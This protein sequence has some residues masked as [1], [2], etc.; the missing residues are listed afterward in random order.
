MDSFPNLNLNT[1]SFPIAF[2]IV[3]F[4]GA[5]LKYDSYL[6]LSMSK[7]HY[8]SNSEGIMKKIK[9]DYIKLR[10]CEYLDFPDIKKENFDAMGLNLGVCPEN[11]NVNINGYWSTPELT[12]LEVYLNMCN[13]EI[14]LLSTC[15][16]QTEI[17][18]FI[19]STAASIT[20]FFQDTQILLDNYSNPMSKVLQASYSYTQPG[21]L[22]VHDYY[23]Q[24]YRIETDDGLFVQSKNTLNFL[25]MNERPIDSTGFNKDSKALINLNIYSSNKFTLYSR[26]YLK[27]F[28]IFAMIGGL[29]RI[30]FLFLQGV[31]LYFIE[32]EKNM[33]IINYLGEYYEDKLGKE[34]SFSNR[35]NDFSNNQIN[36]NNSSI[37]LSNLNFSNFNLNN[38][39]R[40]SLKNHFNHCKTY[41]DER[42]N[43]EQENEKNKVKIL[44]VIRE[45]QDYVNPNY[46]KTA[47]QTINFPINNNKFK[48][49]KN[50]NKNNIISLNSTKPTF[51]DK[52]SK[53]FTYK[54]PDKNNSIFS[55][56][57]TISLNEDLVIYSKDC[58][59]KNDLNFSIYQKICLI[60]F[61]IFGCKSLNDSKINY[62]M[63]KSSNIR[64]QLD[65]LNIIIQLNDI[66][67]LKNYVI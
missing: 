7:V 15:K 57:K 21:V 64:C 9:S 46:K 4:D 45:E 41:I 49:S 2:T 13:P 58:Y 31:N 63:K 33:I 28:E 65:V 60:F 10:K 37:D 44:T 52:F 40:H 54:M 50:S 39:K 61:K 3:D 14:N 36:I 38:R 6:T 30:I 5:P 32:L 22:K 29:Y 53:N 67:K 48:I 56:F 43:D 27:F 47:L 8:K 18:N 11:F 51:T 62:F 20:F 35:Q 23:I 26:K 19:S 34:K 66:E 24:N 12:F 1:S 55:Q 25:R 16:N 17:E 42:K 59:K